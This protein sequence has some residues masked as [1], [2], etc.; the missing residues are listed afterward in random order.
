M[1]DEMLTIAEAAR[2]MGISGHMIREIIAAKEIHT[3]LPHPGAKRR[4]IWASELER[5]VQAKRSNCEVSL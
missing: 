2:R 5:Y 4:K 3:F 1:T